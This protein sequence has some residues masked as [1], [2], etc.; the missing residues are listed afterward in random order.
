MTMKKRPLTQ[1][2]DYIDLVT[3]RKWWI[4]IPAVVVP[5]LVFC[6]GKKLP[7]VYKSETLILVAP[8]KVPTDYVKPTV[9]GDVSDR[10]QTL[11]QQILSRT[12]LDA[13]ID[14]FNLYPQMKKTSTRDQVVER[15]RSDITVEIVADPRPE[16]RSVGAF[17]I[18]YMGNDPAV[19]QAVVQRLAS[20]FISE[21]LKAREMQ[22]NG[23]TA[24]IEDAL[25]QTKAK[26][27]DQEDAIRKF[28]AQNMGSLPEQEQANLT[29]LSQYQAMLQSASDDLGRA[30]Q[31]RVYLESMLAAYDKA[32]P[33]G[34]NSGL[35]KKL[36]DLRTQLAAAEQMYTPQHPDVIR[37]KHDVAAVEAQIAS[38]RPV[39]DEPDVN[40]SQLTAIKQEIAAKKAKKAQ[41][42]QQI[43]RVQG[44]IAML[45]SVEMR[46]ADLN[47]DYE[48]T[49][50]QYKTLLEKRDSSM[51][52]A[53]MEKRAEGEQFQVLDPANY[54]QTPIKPDL[55]QLNALGLLGGIGLGLSLAF[56]SHMRDNRIHGMADL[57][58]YLNVPLLA[59]IPRIDGQPAQAAKRAAA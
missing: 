7:K 11:S 13:V 2:S 54:P 9:N 50:A 36:E 16:R 42:E 51:L 56:L 40:R 5:L 26:L 53:D 39:A 38:S 31:Q 23:T 29:V 8:Q 59:Q 57:E 6:V 20:L 55:A 33:A 47:R 12:R 18:S 27:A 43:E 25:A 22:A 19:V 10:L 15:M 41:I 58:Y 35:P 28:K 48:T 46:F 34:K 44:H 4:I 49:K 17:R 1:L 21:N 37:L 24:F 14:E 3:R 32:G 30:E 52:A 45:P